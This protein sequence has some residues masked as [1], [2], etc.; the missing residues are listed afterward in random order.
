MQNRVA[1]KALI[2]TDPTM[3]AEERKALDAAL[4]LKPLKPKVIPIPPS[5]TARMLT[6]TTTTLR[7]WEKAGRL[8]PIR[9]SSRKVR[10]DRNEIERIMAEGLP[11][12]GGATNE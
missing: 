2:D 9:Y 4:N 8:I 11:E 1:I 7:R 10:Y 5:E 3:T 6:V 12:N